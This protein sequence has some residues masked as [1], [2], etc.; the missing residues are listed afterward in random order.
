M[1]LAHTLA[2]SAGSQAKHLR[3]LGTFAKRGLKI[4]PAV[5]KARNEALRSFK[6]AP[7]PA[8][9][10]GGEAAKTTVAR[11]SRKKTPTQAFSARTLRAHASDAN[12][13]AAV[14]RARQ[15]QQVTGTAKLLQQLESTPFEK[16]TSD[17]ALERLM[18]AF[19]KLSADQ[20]KSRWQA[21]VKGSGGGGALAGM[22][23]G[24]GVGLARAA[25]GGFGKGSL[26]RIAGHAGT[27]WLL[28]A[29]GGAAHGALTH[30]AAA[31]K[32]GASLEE[33]ARA[34]SRQKRS[35]RPRPVSAAKEQGR[36]NI[37]AWR[38]SKMKGEPKGLIEVLFG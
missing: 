3:R 1:S 27:G 33:A 35:V 9:R 13:A 20:P 5:V 11:V 21:A 26:A 17:A 10:P 34:L 38:R 2:M 16:L 25:K 15:G 29:A 19:V 14:Q 24:A 7:L 37:E 6:P 28:G 22:L 23:G 36:K 4:D 30:K 32:P 18:L 31:W 12:P 8:F